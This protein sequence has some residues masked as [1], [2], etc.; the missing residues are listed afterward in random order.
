MKDS[1]SYFTA[2]ASSEDLFFSFMGNVSTRFLL[3]NE[4]VAAQF[5]LELGAAR[6]AAINGGGPPMGGHAWTKYDP[7]FWLQWLEAE[8]AAE[9]RRLLAGAATNG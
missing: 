5:S 9:A 8:T 2:S 7:G 1:S 6:Y 4:W 3:P